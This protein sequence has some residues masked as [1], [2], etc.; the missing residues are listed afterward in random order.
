MT[1]KAIAIVG[2]AVTLIL[3]R[4]ASAHTL[5]S[6]YVELAAD[7]R[8]ISGRV[9]LAARDVHDAIGL[10]SNGD[11][12][13]HWH[14]IAAA[15][16]QVRAYVQS[17]VSLISSG[18]ACVTV[19]GAL[20]AMD[21]PDG[22]HVAIDLTARCPSD[23]EPLTIDYRAIHDLD[24]Q[25]RGLLRLAGIGGTAAALAI[26]P[27]RVVLD[28]GDGAQVA[29][30][31]REGIWHIWIGIDHLAFLIALLLPAVYRRGVNGQWSPTESYR[32]TLTDVI[33]IVTAFSL[34]HSVT[35]I[36]SALGW[37]QLPPRLVETAIAVSVALA[38]ANNVIRVVDAR[39]TVAFALGLVHGF[40]FSN[41]L[42]D[43]GLSGAGMVGALLGFNVGVEIGQAT[44]VV[45][46]LPIAYAVRRTAAYRIAL[47]AGSVVMVAIAAHWSIERLTS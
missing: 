2:L 3:T 18:G 34:A 32:A 14:E 47:V 17:R 41:V 30:F 1:S 9:T 4:A 44:I 16:D 27:G 7:G 5:S 20:S 31:V 43:L 40:G 22:V 39:W 28:S 15:R 29:N 26:G 42:D 37:V 13:L 35:L 36:A 10:D 6:G 38:A 33:T 46:L 45:I 23:A 11:G 12:R 8:N 24:A 25:H 21:R 19:F